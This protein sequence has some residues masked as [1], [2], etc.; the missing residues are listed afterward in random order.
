MTVAV[1]IR[2]GGKLCTVIL[3]LTKRTLLA[4]APALALLFAL[5]SSYRT[6]PS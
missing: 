4:K 1:Q 5:P 6:A 3:N 2:Q